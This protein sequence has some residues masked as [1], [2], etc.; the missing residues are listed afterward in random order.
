MRV[1]FTPEMRERLRNRQYLDYTFEYQAG[2]D[3]RHISYIRIVGPL[4]DEIFDVEKHGEYLY[5]FLTWPDLDDYYIAIQHAMVILDV[6]E[7]LF[8][9]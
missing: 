9:I 8:E 1:Q 2:L 7:G 6:P 3:R 4:I 5:R